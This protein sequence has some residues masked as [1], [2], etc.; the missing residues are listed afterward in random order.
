[1]FDPDRDPVSDRNKTYLL[2]SWDAAGLCDWWVP[3][4]VLIECRGERLPT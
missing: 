1:M 4:D 2:H 3:N